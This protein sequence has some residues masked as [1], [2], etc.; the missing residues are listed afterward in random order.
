MDKKA[1]DLNRLQRL[2]ERGR[3][4]A[5]K[6]E[7]KARLLENQKYDAEAKKLSDDIIA[8]LPKEIEKEA[9]K[10]FDYV[11]VYLPFGYQ[12][13]NRVESNVS[14]WCW[15]NGLSVKNEEMRPSDDCTEDVLFISWPKKK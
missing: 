13:K 7:H 5:E 12:L 1:I 10:G 8:G 2:T 11:I 14:S 15:K 6:R 9:K 3:Q 4:R